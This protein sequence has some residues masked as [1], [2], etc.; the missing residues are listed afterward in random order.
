VIATP[1]LLYLPMLYLCQGEP[2]PT[3]TRHAG[4]MV[5]GQET[6]FHY[7][8]GPIGNHGGYQCT[9]HPHVSAY[10]ITTS[11]LPYIHINHL[12]YLWCIHT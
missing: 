8:I 10:R 3:G 2:A 4:W 12:R 1:M 11:R 7:I 5:C 9:N 6:L